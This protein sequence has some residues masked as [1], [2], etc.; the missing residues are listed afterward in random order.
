[1]LWSQRTTSSNPKLKRINM[2]SNKVLLYDVATLNVMI[3]VN[4]NDT[5]SIIK[6][7]SAGRSHKV[8][9]YKVIFDHL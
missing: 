4:H 3:T 7:I 5:I 6:T 8:N 9:L 2:A 1:M